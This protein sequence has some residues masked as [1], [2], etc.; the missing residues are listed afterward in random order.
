[1]K[2]EKPSYF[3]TGVFRSNGLGYQLMGPVPSSLLA[4]T[5]LKNKNPWMKL[6]AVLQRAKKGDF[7]ALPVMIGCLKEADSW[8]LA[9]ACAELMG[10]AGSAVFLR[11]VEKQFHPSSPETPDVSPGNPA[12]WA[13]P[14]W[15]PWNLTDA[16]RLR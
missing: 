9:Q 3:G 12:N 8:V 15:N 10:D 6:A 5:A 16:P 14:R 11:E 1:M 2:F 4:E 13:S 7:S